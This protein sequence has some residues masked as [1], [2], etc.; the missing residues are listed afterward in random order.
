LT[1]N[2]PKKKP[3]TK[4]YDN[5]CKSAHAG[6]HVG[7]LVTLKQVLD[8]IEKANFF[9]D[10]RGAFHY[11]TDSAMFKRK[12]AV[13]DTLLATLGRGPD[14]K[15]NLDNVYFV[16]Y[17]DMYKNTLNKEFGTFKVTWAGKTAVAH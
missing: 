8:H 3:A 14:E 4:W 5:K 6:I 12:Q 9:C 1:L 16:S 17:R 11:L 7:G 15:D 13:Q 10:N 2:T